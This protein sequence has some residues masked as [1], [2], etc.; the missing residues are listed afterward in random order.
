MANLWLIFIAILMFTLVISSGWKAKIHCCADGGTNR[1]YNSLK[2]NN[3]PLEGYAMNHI[4]HSLLW[5][6]RF[7]P[8]FIKGDMDSIKEDIRSLYEKLVSRQFILTVRIQV[9]F[10]RA[11]P[12]LLILTKIRLI[13]WSVSKRLKRLKKQNSEKRCTS[14]LS[15]E[16]DQLTIFLA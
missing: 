3:V 6:S 12:L 15:M 1:L 8:E 13:S 7:L 10:F 9:Y 4:T 14:T 5:F 16:L 2:S 11:S